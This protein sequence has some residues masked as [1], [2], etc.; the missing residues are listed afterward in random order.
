MNT[1]VLI[2]DHEMMRKGISEWIT[3]TGQWKVVGEAAS[4][5]EAHALFDSYPEPPDLV[6]LDISLR[7]DFGLDLIPWLKEKYPYTAG[8]NSKPAIL[9]YSVYQGY[10][11]IREAMT[12]GALGYVCKTDSDAEFA[13]AIE[14]VL[15]GKRYI[16]QNLTQKIFAVPDI[17]IG[18]TKREREIFSLVQ[19]GMDNRG[20]AK[21]LSI[22]RGTV[23]NYIS[24]IYDKT[25]A[26]NREDLK[27]L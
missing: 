19:N 22:H 18:L 5:D 25:G 3:N 15:L 12:R 11:L 14:S 6:L 27:K 21:T 24:R 9:V 10:T 23:E 16:D 26:K 1:I 13:R 8:E 20:I 17:L 7:K 2:E 4:L